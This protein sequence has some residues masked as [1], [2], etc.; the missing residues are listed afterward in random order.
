MTNIPIINLN[1]GELSPQID[2]RADTDMYPAGCRHLEN[3]I[4]MIYGP[5][6][7]R[8]GTVMVNA[9]FNYDL[10]IYS[11]LVWGG[12]VVVYDG[13][14]VNTGVDDN[15]LANY[16]CFEGDVVCYDND[17]VTI[18]AVTA[19]ASTVLCYENSV[20]CHDGEVIRN[21]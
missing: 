7:R 5:V 19:F 9:V 14:I 11:I 8:P 18:G 2:A 6:E 4:P 21:V 17:I 12:D 3:F 16:I 10:I 15:F 1:G 13:N 20:V